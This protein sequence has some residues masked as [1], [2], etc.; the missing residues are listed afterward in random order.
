MTYENLEIFIKGILNSI[1]GLNLI[2]HPVKIE[3]DREVDVRIVVYT[4][5]FCEDENLRKL[6]HSSKKYF[7]EVS[8]ET[9]EEGGVGFE[10]LNS[11][12][13]AI[14]TRGSKTNDVVNKDAGKQNT[15][16]KFISEEEWESFNKD[17]KQAL[18][19]YKTCYVDNF[20]WVKIT[21]RSKN[22]S[23]PTI[24]LELPSEY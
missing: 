17:Y 15:N 18:E 5:K 19:D 8:L 10:H 4:T 1:P 12:I 16:L 11:A 21:P 20:P 9:F 13:L 3:R 24:S 7:L 14:L 23:L 22:S 2:I 6:T